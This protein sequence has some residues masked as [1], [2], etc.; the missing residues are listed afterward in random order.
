MFLYGEILRS[1][2]CIHYGC[3][4]GAIAVLHTWRQNL[5][6]HSHLHIIPAAGYSIK[7]EEFL[8]RF[9]LHILPNR[10][11]R[12][13]YYGIYHHR[14]KQSLELKFNQETHNPTNKPA[15]IESRAERVIR[16][17]GFDPSICPECKQAKMLVIKKN[18]SNLFAY[19]SSTVFA[20]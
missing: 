6:L 4:T 12:I 14:T 15:K 2:G 16:I 8:R 17:T 19:K 9:C 18:A 11:V 13:R 7:G 1:F 5:S 20:L 3:E 10:F